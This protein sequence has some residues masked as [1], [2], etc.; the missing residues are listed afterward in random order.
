MNAYSLDLREQMVEAKD[1]GLPTFEV[2]R[3]FG[4]DLILLT[5]TEHTDAA[6]S[7]AEESR[8]EAGQGTTAVAVLPKAIAIRQ[9][10][11]IGVSLFDS[12]HPD[13]S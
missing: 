11:F 1:R 12:F 5:V 7:V 6:V 4:A 10:S 13:R 9:G 8:P 3:A 2:T